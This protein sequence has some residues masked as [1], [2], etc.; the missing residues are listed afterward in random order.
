M[1]VWVIDRVIDWLNE[2][3]IVI[4]SDGGLMTV[5]DR[6]FDNFDWL[7]DWLFQFVWLFGMIYLAI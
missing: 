4:E 5:I 3:M 7:I 6:L 1:I 2:W